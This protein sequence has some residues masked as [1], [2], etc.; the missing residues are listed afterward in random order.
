MDQALSF[1]HPRDG[2]HVFA[3]SWEGATLLGTTD[4]DHEAPLDEEPRISEGEVA[5]LMEVV[6]RYFPALRLDRRD[7]MATWAGVRPVVGTQRAD[8]SAE[9]REGLLV[10][11]RGLVSV[12]GGKLTTVRPTALAALERVAARLPRRPDMRSSARLFDEADPA[13]VE[14]PALD[15]ATRRR[16]VGHYGLDAADVLAAAREGDLA[17]VP[18]TR[19]LWAQ[20][21]FAARA[22][23]V[24]HLDDLLLRRVRIGL[25]LPEGGAS[26]L[27]AIRTRVQ[28]EIGWSD[29]RWIA[30]EAA[31]R[32]RWRA[33]HSVPGVSGDPV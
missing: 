33:L 22:E 5:Y 12:T 17:L 29:E 26:L 8:P 20:I 11:E 13:S 21:R 31:Y 9:S 4:C 3:C 23:G 1:T 18:G 30:E 25:V 27:P 14:H 2:R 7:V 32:A 16:L 6:T 19:T 15:R 24:T 10:D 28:D